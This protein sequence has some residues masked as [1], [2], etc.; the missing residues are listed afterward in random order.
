MVER[1]LWSLDP[2]W[3][4]LRVSVHTRNQLHSMGD[5]REAGVVAED[6]YGA[7]AV[8]DRR[9]DFSISPGERGWKESVFCGRNTTGRTG[10]LRHTEAVVCPVFERTFGRSGGVFERRLQ[11]RLRYPSG[12]KSLAEQV[13]RQR[14]P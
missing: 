8:D 14:P 7:C 5:T 1:M 11:D 12:R 2:E 6:E 10:A 4:V 9:D 3:K 13:G